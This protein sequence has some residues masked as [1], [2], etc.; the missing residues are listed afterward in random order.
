MNS[1]NTHLR[2]ARL[3]TDQLWGATQSTTL[4]SDTEINQ[5][6]GQSSSLS[7]T[8]A[9]IN[10]RPRQLHDVRPHV[11]LPAGSEPARG[12]KPRGASH[13]PDPMSTSFCSAP[14]PP[15]SGAALVGA[16]EG[17]A[18]HTHS[19]TSQREREAILHHTPDLSALD[20]SSVDDSE[21]ASA[22]ST[23]PMLTTL[24]SFWLARRA[25]RP[26]QRGRKARDLKRGTA[27]GQLIHFLS[28]GTESGEHHRQPRRHGSRCTRALMKTLGRSKWLNGLC[29]CLHSGCTNGTGPSPSIEP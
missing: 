8:A 25:D 23:I 24:L 19:L 18:P 11:S 14:T 4:V 27:H 13:R 16:G 9:R 3:G 6:A 10:Q 7:S 29:R 12:L 21:R 2:S 28:S 22:A 15:S 26:R 5:V 17:E 1:I 20:D